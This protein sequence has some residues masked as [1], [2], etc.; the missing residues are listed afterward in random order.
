MSIDMRSGRVDPS[1]RIS[2][3]TIDRGR[4][5]FGPKRLLRRSSLTSTETRSRSVSRS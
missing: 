1:R 3:S 2:T 5:R 4:R